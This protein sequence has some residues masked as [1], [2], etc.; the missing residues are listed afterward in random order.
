MVEW[1][2][3]RKKYQESKSVGKSKSFCQMMF[4]FFLMQHKTKNNVKCEKI[5]RMGKNINLYVKAF[6]II[7]IY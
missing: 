3:N 6:V 2:K 5:H 7:L 1:L 4:F